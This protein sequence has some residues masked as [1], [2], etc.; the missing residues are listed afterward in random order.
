MFRFAPVSLCFACISIYAIIACNFLVQI[1]QDLNSFFRSSAPIVFCGP[2][3]K[4]WDQGDPIQR[5]MAKMHER[6]YD[7]SDLRRSYKKTENEDYVGDKT[8]NSREKKHKTL[9]GSSSSSKVVIKAE[10]VVFAKY[11]Q[12]MKTL[13]SGKGFN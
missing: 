9:E 6:R 12:C 7:M 5:A 10:Y 2:H 3:T 4:D 13:N 8:T 11:K 1:N